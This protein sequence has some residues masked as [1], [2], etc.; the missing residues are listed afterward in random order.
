MCV[1]SCT[2]NLLYLQEDNVGGSGG[3]VGGSDGGGGSSGNNS[4]RGSDGGS[5]CRT[6]DLALEE[7]RQ[8]APRSDV[9]SPESFNDD[10]L[11]PASFNDD[12]T[13]SYSRNE[14]FMSVDATPRNDPKE[15][16]FALS[17][18]LINDIV[19]E[20][21]E[22]YN[23]SLKNVLKE[24]FDLLYNLLDNNI[25]NDKT[26]IS[27]KR[28]SGF[29]SN[30]DKNRLSQELKSKEASISHLEENISLHKLEI[31]DLNGQVKVSSSLTW[32]F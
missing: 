2:P 5:R 31:Q 22:K 7:G 10:V 6:Q 13:D 15:Q 1:S 4:S 14:A 3:G 21:L 24:H 9:L 17:S 27:N 32:Y 11:S 25:S 20:L 18:E 8:D 30:T 23:S 12:H 29:Y 19:S 16:L 28:P 26:E